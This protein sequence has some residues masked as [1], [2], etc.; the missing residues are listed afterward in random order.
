MQECGDILWDSVHGLEDNHES[1]LNNLN[2][3]ERKKKRR[4]F[5]SHRKYELSAVRWEGKSRNNCSVVVIE[6]NYHGENCSYTAVFQHSPEKSRKWR[7][8]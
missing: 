4:K 6:K 5:F 3:R 2:N 8:A 7:H 1:I